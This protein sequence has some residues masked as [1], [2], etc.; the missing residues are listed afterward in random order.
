MTSPDEWAAIP[1]PP[2]E[3][4]DEIEA[5]ANRVADTGEVAMSDR[6]I[7]VPEDVWQ[8]YDKLISPARFAGTPIRLRSGDTIV[9]ILRVTETTL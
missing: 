9:H 8:D 6:W 3:L 5:L 2:E 7:A 4:R 1:P